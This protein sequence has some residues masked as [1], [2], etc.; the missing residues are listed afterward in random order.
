[1]PAEAG[2]GPIVV[3]MSIT[4][5]VIAIGGGFLAWDNHKRQQER[6]RIAAAEL[7]AADRARAD[8]IRA[9]SAAQRQVAAAE[10]G[11]RRA[12]LIRRAVEQLS[13]SQPMTQCAGASA[14]GRLRAREE[15]RSLEVMLESAGSGS[16]RTCAA[17]ALVDLGETNTALVAYERWARGDDSDLQRSAL[18]G[19]GEIGPSAAETGMPYLRDALRS[20]HMDLRYLAVE[21]LSKMGP[22]ATP[23]LQLATS[24]ADARVRARAA[25]ALKA[26]R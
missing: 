8:Q 9:E 13:S 20:P 14:L 18:M 24:D 16:V 26:P 6:D 25:A 19:F 10:T 1:M 15:I 4:L 2:R 7:A 11:E 21:S 5:A 17:G 3:L 12:A 23:L 22:S